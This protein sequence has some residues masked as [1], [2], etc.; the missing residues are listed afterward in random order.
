M[1]KT[2]DITQYQPHFIR[3]TKEFQE[4]AE[5]E[6]PEL[7]FLWKE[8][9]QVFSEQFIESLTKN[10]C[11]RWEKMI[12]IAPKQGLEERRELIRARINEKL[13]FTDRMLEQMLDILL[14]EGGYK[15]EL[16][17][18]KYTLII[19]VSLSNRSRY[20]EVDKML[21]RVVPVNLVLE[22]SLWFCQHE[23]VGRYRHNLL[24]GYT[25]KQIRE[26]QLPVFVSH[27]EL[28][29][30]VHESLTTWSHEHLRNQGI[31]NRK[32]QKNEIHNKL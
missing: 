21:K 9:E 24:S 10:G 18:N 6:N 14:G 16:F 13:P 11:K 26:K 29:G 25:H 28:K 22:M 17:P 30:E 7:S 4:L 2:V 27:Q 32:E 1:A 20:I 3:C 23:E 8:L 19:R 15:K 5:T 12:K 31:Q